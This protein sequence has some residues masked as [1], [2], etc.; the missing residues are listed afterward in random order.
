MVCHGKDGLS[1]NISIHSTINPSIYICP[2]KV[3]ALDNTMLYRECTLG[4]CQNM[5]EI[6][7]LI[8]LRRG[9]KSAEISISQ[10]AF[11][12]LLITEVIKKICIYILLS[13][14]SFSY[15]Q[16]PSYVTKFSL[17]F[18]SLSDRIQFMSF[19]HTT[20]CSPVYLGSYLSSPYDGCGLE[21]LDSKVPGN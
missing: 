6:I 4:S 5:V 1:I 17:T 10:Q 8:S 2:T 20:L 16:C 14:L 9:T 18:W 7:P 15:P 13:C 21:Y 3:I 11:K 19:W 12:S